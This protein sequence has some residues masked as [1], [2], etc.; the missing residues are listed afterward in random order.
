MYLAKHILAAAGE[1]VRMMRAA[2]R[3]RSDCHRKRMSLWLCGKHERYASASATVENG[4]SPGSNSLYWSRAARLKAVSTTV[5]KK[6]VECQRSLCIL[7]GRV[8]GNEFVMSRFTQPRN[9]NNA[10]RN[11]TSHACVY[12]FPFPS[13]IHAH[14]ANGLIMMDVLCCRRARIL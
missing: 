13:S 3:C 11:P 7:C 4:Y 6:Y 14:F 5:R 9:N 2:N 10:I 12:F 1:S 8:A